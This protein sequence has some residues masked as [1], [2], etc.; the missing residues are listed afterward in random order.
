MEKLVRIDKNGTK[1][2][3]DDVCHAC[4]GTGIWGYGRP[5]FKCNGTGKRITKRVER[6]PE[7]EKKLADKRLEKAIAEAPRKNKELFSKLNL[8]DEGNA[9]MVLGNTYQIK[10]EL[11]EKGAHY[12]SVLGWYFD[13]NDSS[14]P[15]ERVERDSFMT[16]DDTGE[17]KLNWNKAKELVDEIKSKYKKSQ[18][19]NKEE[20]QSN[21]QW[22]GEVGQRITKNVTLKKVYSFISSFT[23]DLM[24][25]YKFEGKSGSVLI[26]RTTEKDGLE[27]GNKYELTGTIKEHSEYRDEKQTILTRCKYIK[28]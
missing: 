3:E 18:A 2:Y 13:H 17:Y 26:W 24:C 21:S 15:I 10:D 7:Y 14:Y 8:D 5:C 11:K 22:I 16:P 1:Y 20:K 9:Y 4:N 27:E 19:P 23:G 6:T 12:N 28:K 25:I